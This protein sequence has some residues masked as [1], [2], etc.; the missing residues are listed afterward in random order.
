MKY[1]QKTFDVLASRWYVDRRRAAPPAPLS[2]DRQDGGWAP[3][4]NPGGTGCTGLVMGSRVASSSIA[5]KLARLGPDSDSSSIFSVVSPF[6]W[7]SLLQILK[8]MRI[9]PPI[10]YLCPQKNYWIIL[11]IGHS[12]LILQIS[13]KPC[14]VSIGF[15]LFCQF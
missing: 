6:A 9:N 8:A 10:L 7:V 15:V 12:G 2:V 3:W 1:L 11:S 4:R 13:I 14:I 5:A